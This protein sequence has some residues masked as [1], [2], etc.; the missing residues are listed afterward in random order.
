MRRRGLPAVK[1]LASAA[2]RSL[3]FVKAGI[4]ITEAA[5]HAVQLD[6][7]ACAHV[8]PGDLARALG[9]EVRRMHDAG[10]RLADQMVQRL[11]P[12]VRVGVEAVGAPVGEHGG[13][14]E[15][16]VT[17]RQEHQHIAGTVAGRERQQL[18][19]IASVGQQRLCQRDQVGQSARRFGPAR[20]IARARSRAS[21]PN[22]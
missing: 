6:T 17:L 20:R 12:D 16:D 15:Q 22:S 13:A 18:N 21:A 5:P 1:P 14:R 8:V 19:A 4:L 10:V 2:K 9:R 7:W 3:G 11:Q